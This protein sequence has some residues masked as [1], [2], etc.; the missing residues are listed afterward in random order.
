M[1]EAEGR[2][3]PPTRNS[4]PLLAEIQPYEEV[5]TVNSE[6]QRS[7]RSTNRNAKADSASA[8]AI[9]GDTDRAGFRAIQDSLAHQAQEDSLAPATP[10]STPKPP[11]Q[12]CIQRFSRGDKYEG[13]IG[14]ASYSGFGTMTYRDGASYAGQVG[15][16]SQSSGS[17]T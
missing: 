13:Q 12:L 9:F 8:S 1:A 16:F 5:E 10:T 4:N 6:Q 14:V 11:L 15:P 2:R 3:L 7:W 17:F